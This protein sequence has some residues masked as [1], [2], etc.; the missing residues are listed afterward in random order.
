MKR[1]VINFLLTLI[2]IFI[3][4]A[5]VEQTINLG[6]VEVSAPIVPPP[7]HLNINK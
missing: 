1:A 6:D 2:L 3:G 7:T 4:C 5:S